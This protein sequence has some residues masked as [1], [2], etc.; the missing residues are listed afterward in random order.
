MSA[1]LWSHQATQ[2]IFLC[3]S[4]E[5]STTFYHSPFHTLLSSPIWWS[6]L[7]NLRPTGQR[8]CLIYSALPGPT[9]QASSM[10]LISWHY[11]G[12][13]WWKTCWRSLLETGVSLLLVSSFST[14]KKMISLYVCFKMFLFQRAKVELWTLYFSIPYSK[15]P[16]PLTC[17]QDTTLCYTC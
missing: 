9:P 16:Q 17:G 4:T 15:C 3:T 7:P 14:R 10:S 5:F 1:L 2:A 8:R 13:K 11:L 12:L 6:P